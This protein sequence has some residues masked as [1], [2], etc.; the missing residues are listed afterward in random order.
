M[1]TRNSRGGARKKKATCG[2]N[3]SPQ[4]RQ[5]ATGPPEKDARQHKEG[6]R[7]NAEG[8]ETETANDD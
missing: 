8:A 1:D 6:A 7:Q 2:I 5:N 4:S 3:S